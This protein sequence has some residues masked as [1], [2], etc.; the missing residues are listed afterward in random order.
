MVHRRNNFCLYCV[1]QAGSRK[2]S[3]SVEWVDLEGGLGTGFLVMLITSPWWNLKNMMRH[4]LRL[5]LSIG[6]VGTTSAGHAFHRHQVC[7]WWLTTQCTAL[8]CTASVLLMFLWCMG[9]R[10]CRCIQNWAD[11]CCA[12]LIFGATG[13]DL[14]SSMSFPGSQGFCWLC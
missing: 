10:H 8:C 4:G 12:C 9:P 1:L 2:A 11:K 14:Q 3:A 5:R 6:P 7:R 13:P